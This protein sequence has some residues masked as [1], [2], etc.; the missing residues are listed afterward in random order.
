MND[1]QLVM[2]WFD[3]NYP[4]I[5]DIYIPL[6][7]HEY[8]LLMNY[9]E[10]FRDLIRSSFKEMFSSILCVEFSRSTGLSTEVFYSVVD[11]KLMN[12]FIYRLEDLKI[13]NLDEELN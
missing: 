10:V 11:D 2:E 5:M 7:H 3:S 9:D 8:S 1:T 6:A 4:L 12:D 13:L